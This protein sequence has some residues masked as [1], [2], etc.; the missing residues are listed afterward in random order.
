MSVNMNLISSEHFDILCVE[1]F[2]LMGEAALPLSC[3]FLVVIQDSHLTFYKPGAPVVEKKGGKRW[4][5]V[6]W[7]TTLAKKNRAHKKQ[8]KA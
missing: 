5:P 6:E 8:P 7:P 4:S 1:L 2:N 3:L